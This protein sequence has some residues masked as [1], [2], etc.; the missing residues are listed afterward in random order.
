MFLYWFTTT[1]KFSDGGLTNEKKD[2]TQMLHQ[3]AER[4]ATNVVWEKLKLAEFTRQRLL[5]LASRMKHRGALSKSSNLSSEASAD[6]GVVTLFT[7]YSGMDKM[8]AAAALAAD[9]NLELYKVDLSRIVSKYIGETEK[10]L[11]HLFEQSDA[12]SAVL[13]FDEADAL[14]GKR[15]EVKDSH[16]RYANME[17]AYLLQRMETYTGI[18]ILATNKTGDLEEAF[19]RRLDCVIDFL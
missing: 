5:E 15:T 2:N 9:L 8:M 11:D 1:I 12:A 6:A 4:L 14:F 19:V 7:G 3:L 17:T 16:D 13:F 18:V 10:N